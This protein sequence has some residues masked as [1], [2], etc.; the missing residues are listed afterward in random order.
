MNRLAVKIFVVGFAVLMACSSGNSPVYDLA[1]FARDLREK[2]IAPE[3]TADANSLILGREGTVVS[4]GDISVGAFEYPDR[5]AAIAAAALIAEDGSSVDGI[6]EGPINWPATPHFFRKG[7]LMV[8]YV[9]DDRP[10]ADL[11]KVVLGPQF[12]GGHGSPE[13]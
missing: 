13:E 1:Q 2:E 5:P 4:W 12:A 7:R 3:L 9:G 11:L 8:L 10:T 6:S